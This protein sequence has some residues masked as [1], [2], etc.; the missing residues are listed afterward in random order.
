MLAGTA[1]IEQ[2]ETGKQVNFENSVA[3]L[4]PFD[5]VVAKNAKAKGLGVNVLAATADKSASGV[6]MGKY[7]VEL[8]WHEPQKFDKGAEI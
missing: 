7:G 2:D 4:L 6:T 8:R 5:P 1:A 3:F